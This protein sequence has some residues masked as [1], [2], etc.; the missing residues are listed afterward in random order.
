VTR[1]HNRS[2]SECAPSYHPDA[3][4]PA[5]ASAL[6]VATTLSATRVGKHRPAL[7]REVQDDCENRRTLLLVILRGDICVSETKK[8]APERTMPAAAQ[9]IEIPFT[10]HSR[11]VRDCCGWPDR[12]PGV[13]KVGLD[14]AANPS[15]QGL[16]LISNDTC[17]V[18][19]VDRSVQSGRTPIPPAKEDRGMNLALLNNNSLILWVQQSP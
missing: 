17:L 14:T 15:V 4:N 3:G 10:L 11:R 2:D 12:R 6:T 13:P 9:P 16:A 5:V 1:P 18:G 19:V 7:L 8:S